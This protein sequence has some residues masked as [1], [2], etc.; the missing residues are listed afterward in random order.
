MIQSGGLMSIGAGLGAGLFLRW[1]TMDPINQDYDQ[2]KKEI[3]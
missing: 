1:N 3:K 2:G